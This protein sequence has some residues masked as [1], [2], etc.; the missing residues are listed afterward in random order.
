MR[1]CACCV[2]EKKVGGLARRTRK[3]TST[4]TGGGK[5][6]DCG[7]AAWSPTVKRLR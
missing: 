7:H 4:R 6:A 3:L 1:R 5:R 2:R